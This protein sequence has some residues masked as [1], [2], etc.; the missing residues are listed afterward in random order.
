MDRYTLEQQKAIVDLYIEAF[1]DG[2]DHGNLPHRYPPLDVAFWE[3][4]QILKQLN[5]HIP[6]EARMRVVEW[7]ESNYKKR[8]D[9]SALNRDLV[10]PEIVVHKDRNTYLRK[11]EKSIIA[12]CL[13][14]CTLFGAGAMWVLCPVLGS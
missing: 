14:V 6:E 8:E 11:S 4:E 5:C 10:M 12:I 7:G 9:I 13:L 3:S 1:Y 2:R